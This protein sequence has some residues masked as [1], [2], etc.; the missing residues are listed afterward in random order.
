MKTMQSKFIKGQYLQLPP[1][2]P[3]TANPNNYCTS[4]LQ[5]SDK[6]K[7]LSFHGDSYRYWIYICT[8]AQRLA[9][10]V[11]LAIL[12]G[13]DKILLVKSINKITSNDGKGL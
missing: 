7:Y 4:Q 13:Y 6:D 5:N 2:Q 3:P 11:K 10:L 12:A 9:R 1:P 8:A